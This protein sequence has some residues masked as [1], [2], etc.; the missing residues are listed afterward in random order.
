MWLNSLFK[1]SHAKV[2]ICL[3]ITPAGVI[4]C[5]TAEI[6]NV[7]SPSWPITIVKDLPIS[8]EFGAQRWF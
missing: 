4:F 5:V 7:P 1:S 3:L 2:N 8:R 6:L